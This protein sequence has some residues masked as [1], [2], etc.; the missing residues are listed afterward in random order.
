[1][2]CPVPL[3][4]IRSCCFRFKSACLTQ[5]TNEIES[6]RWMAATRD[7]AA[8][9]MQPPSQRH[10]H[11]HRTTPNPSSTLHQA[12]HFQMHREHMYSE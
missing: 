5:G 3:F 1:M 11:T 7:V 10:D 4:S 8:R 12:A 2:L 9:G 6:T